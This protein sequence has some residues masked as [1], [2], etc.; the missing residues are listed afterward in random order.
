[1]VSPVVVPTGGCKINTLLSVCN[2]P[3]LLSC[4][5]LHAEVPLTLKSMEQKCLQVGLTAA[6][7]I[8]FDVSISSEFPFLTLLILIYLIQVSKELLV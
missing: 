2:G 7:L 6:N 4:R 3:W 8:T 5:A 1:M